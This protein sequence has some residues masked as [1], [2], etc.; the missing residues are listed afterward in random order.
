MQ[1]ITCVDEVLE[2]CEVCRAFDTAPHAS[3]AETSTVAMFNG[4][5]QV[6]LL[7]LDDVSVPHVLDGF[8]KYS[9]LIPVRTENPQEVWKA[10][11][12]SSI[13]VFG[14]PL[15]IQMDEGEKWRNELWAE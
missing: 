2:Q 12:G 15:C 11:C 8:P 1:L 14:P 10:F 5:L 3:V 6:A 13:G 7:L 4:T 9:L